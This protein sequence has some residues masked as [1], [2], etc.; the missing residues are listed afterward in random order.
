MKLNIAAIL[1]N[2]KIRSFSQCR[3]DKKRIFLFSFIV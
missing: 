2:K 1:F 3:L